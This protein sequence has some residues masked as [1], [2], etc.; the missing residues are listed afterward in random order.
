MS[1]VDIVMQPLTKVPYQSKEQR[2][3]KA[4][5]DKEDNVSIWFGTINGNRRSVDP[6]VLETAWEDIYKNIDLFLLI[7]VPGK[8]RDDPDE[9][10]KVKGNLSK[11]AMALEYTND[12]R[13]HIHVVLKVVHN[14]RVWLDYKKIQ[15][16]YE[17]RIGGK[18]RVHFEIDTSRPQLDSYT[19]MMNYI[20]GMKSKW[21]M[22]NHGQ[23]FP[24][25]QS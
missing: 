12:G 21:K 19:V 8:K 18:C 22:I 1:R 4:K 20:T 25:E 6:K 10:A 15:K 24:P 2:I 11:G 13:P 5:K 23:E 7:N 16:L 14:T 3:K 17:G 9:L